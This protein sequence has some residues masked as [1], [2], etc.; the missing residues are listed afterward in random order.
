MLYPRHLADL[1]SDNLIIV[2]H[3]VTLSRYPPPPAQVSTPLAAAVD[4]LCRLTLAARGAATLEEVPM[5]SSAAPV[6]SG[7]MKDR[8]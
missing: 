7:V 5:N 1:L 8:L 2:S 3:A 6:P 4:R